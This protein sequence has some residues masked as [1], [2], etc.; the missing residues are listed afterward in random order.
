M[1]QHAVSPFDHLIQIGRVGKATEP[2]DHSGTC[3]F[4]VRK[5]DFQRRTELHAADLYS[6]IPDAVERGARIFVLHGEVAAIDADPYVFVQTR[7]RV[8]DVTAER[9][10]EERRSVRDHTAGE[11][12]EKHVAGV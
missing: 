9:C 12:L 2:L 11:E 1:R 7:P 10:G 8:V 4:V 6:A 3:G 5:Y